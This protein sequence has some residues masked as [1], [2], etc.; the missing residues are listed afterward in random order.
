MGW[1]LRDVITGQMGHDHD[2]DDDGVGVRNW[3]MW[4]I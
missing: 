3:N 1:R 2:L 4:N